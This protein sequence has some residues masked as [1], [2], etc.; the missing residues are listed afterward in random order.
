MVS[1]VLV[2]IVHHLLLPDDLQLG[3]SWILPLLEG[4]LW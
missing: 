2:A 1:A 3:P 4:V